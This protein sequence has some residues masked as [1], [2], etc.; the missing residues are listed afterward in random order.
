MSFQSTINHTSVDQVENLESDSSDSDYYMYPITIEESVNTVNRPSST[1]RPIV[2]VKI[3]DTQIDMLADSGAMAS[4]ISL[5]HVNTYLPHVKLEPSD[6]KLMPCG[7]QSLHCEYE[8]KATFE[9]N[10]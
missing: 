7:H 9:A 8:F 6:T 4:L 2:P 5:H 3:N 1:Q 10:N